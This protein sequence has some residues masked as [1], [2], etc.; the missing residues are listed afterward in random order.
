MIELL[1]VM[2]V[3]GI[4]AV[5]AAV[6]FSDASTKA[7]VCAAKSSMRTIQQ[8]LLRYR[9]DN[10]SYPTPRPRVGRDPFAILADVQLA[11][12][13]SPVAYMPAGSF[14][15]PFGPVRNQ[16]IVPVAD[17]FSRAPEGAPNAGLS[18]LY[19]HYPTF[20]RLTKNR[21]INV[22]AVTVLSLG[23][24][25]MD[26]FGAFAPFSKTA[27]PALAGRKGV[28]DPI[29]AR[30]DPTNGTFSAGDLISYSGD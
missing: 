26:S 15:D 11:H 27:L 7:R 8:A 5:I 28:L 3:L 22:N 29:D 16:G 12:L 13:T 6:N 14:M 1:V 10:G 20:S 24:D 19:I 18:L 25:Q 21:Q 30:Y 4:L 2:A 9:V 17:P 23:P